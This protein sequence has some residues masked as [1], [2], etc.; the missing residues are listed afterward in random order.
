MLR[1]L[2]LVL[3]LLTRASA[4]ALVAPRLATRS[5]GGRRVLLRACATEAPPKPKKKQ[6]QKKGG[7]GKGGGGGLPGLTARDADYSAWYNEVIAAGDLVDGSP[8][9]GCM[10]IKPN[11]MALWEAVRDDLDARI[12]ATGCRNAYFPLFIPVS[13]LS[14]EA[15][16]VEGFAKECAVVTHHRLRSTTDADGKSGV[17]PDPG[18]ELEEPLIVRPTSET[19]IWHMFGKWIQGHRD[20]P[21]K[22][23]QWAN[24]VRWE[25]RTRPFLRSAEFLWQEGHTAHATEADAVATAEEMI[26]VYAAPRA[27]PSPRHAAQ[28]GAP[29]RAT[30]PIHFAPTRPPARS[31]G[32]PTSQRSCWRSRRCAASSRRPSAS[33]APR[34]RTRSRR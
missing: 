25:L 7:G 5:A 28:F 11:G 8:V 22:I 13:F 4:V 2:V 18:A 26:D 20:L 12:K 32:T 23:N 14:K 33:P 34:R 29:P 15:E 24:V 3:M 6:Q 21:L 16:H 1:R 17:E 27:A 9:K 19:M 30:R 10:V 31:T